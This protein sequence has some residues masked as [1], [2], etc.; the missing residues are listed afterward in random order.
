MWLNTARRL[1]GHLTAGTILLTVGCAGRSPPAQ[2]PSRTTAASQPRSEGSSERSD[3]TY[4]WVSV[5]IGAEAA[6]MAV[7]TS[8]MMLHD[9]SVRDSNCSAQKICSQTGVDAAQD[10]GLLGGWNAGAWIVA[11]A[12][13]G[14]GGYL[15]WRDPSGSERR[16]AITIDPMG[17]GVGLGVRSRF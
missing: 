17:T 2:D 11:A 6:V 14:V 3:R 12:G 13:L 1:G 9:K 7:G 16:T 8:L 10:I 5:G 4:G 15:L